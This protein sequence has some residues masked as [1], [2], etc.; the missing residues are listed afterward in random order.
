[1]NTSFIC[2]NCQK[3]TLIGGEGRRHLGC[4][5]C[6]CRDIKFATDVEVSPSSDKEPGKV[7]PPVIVKKGESFLASHSGGSSWILTF[8]TPEV[9]VKEPIKLRRKV[10]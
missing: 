10:K 3:E 4:Q 5:N 6:G 7:F 1:M 8:P 2:E 9:E